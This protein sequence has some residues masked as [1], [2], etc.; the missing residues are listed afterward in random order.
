MSAAASPAHSGDS[1]PVNIQRLT[2]EPLSSGHAPG[3]SRDNSNVT[4]RSVSTSH[5]AAHVRTT[6]QPSLP[7]R[8]QMPIRGGGLPHTPPQVTM[9]QEPQRVVTL[10]SPTGFMLG[11]LT[12]MGATT[13]QDDGWAMDNASLAE[14]EEVWMLAS[15]HKQ[16]LPSPMLGQRPSNADQAGY[17]RQRE[18]ASATHSRPSG[19]GTQ[20]LPLRQNVGLVPDKMEQMA[21]DMRELKDSA[22]RTNNTIEMLIQEMRED[23]KSRSRSTRG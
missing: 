20:Y 5:A 21:N 8:L 19:I 23:R 9:A 3:P 6:K 11:Y 14:E 4:R 15:L 17:F 18:F 7:P 2:N 16:G 13:Q 1:S 10:N 22:S 12:G